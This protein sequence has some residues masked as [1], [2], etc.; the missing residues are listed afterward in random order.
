MR[1][2]NEIGPIPS[3]SAGR[4]VN[5]GINSK[6][7]P[8]LKS[9]NSIGLP[10][11]QYLVCERPAKIG[12]RQIP[13]KRSFDLVRDIECTAPIIMPWISCGVGIRVIEGL[14]VVCLFIHTFR[15]PVAG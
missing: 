15:P 3:D 13:D 8:A 5:P 11:A 10:V 2:S 12:F 9:Q 14:L 6:W 1:V 4:I 7:L